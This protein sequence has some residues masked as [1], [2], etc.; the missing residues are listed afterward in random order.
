[1]SWSG[2]SGFISASLDRT[3]KFWDTARPDPLLAIT[4]TKSES[5]GTLFP[6]EVTGASYFW[7]DKFVVL[8]YGQAVGIYGYHLPCLNANA[9]T[10]AEMHQTGTYKCVKSVLVDSG[11]IVGM[12]AS[13]AP[14]SPIALVATTARTIHAVD[15]YTGQKVLDLDTKH[16]RAIHSIAANF[17]GIYTPRPSET[18]D[19]ALTGG[20]DESFKLWDLRSARCERTIPIGSRTVKVGMCF[21]PDSKFVALGTE[22]LGVEIWDIGQGKC[23]SKLRDDIR[24]ITVTWTEWNPSSGK[25]HCGLENGMVKVF[26]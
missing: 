1:L 17:G 15:F 11:K 19:L 24:G 6:D 3:V 12:A 16:E 2:G 9:K 14:T 21:S 8:A 20:L 5:R 26:G 13:N 7:N 10:V 18:P 23:L 4:K 22:R 25:L